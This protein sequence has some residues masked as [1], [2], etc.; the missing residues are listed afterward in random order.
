MRRIKNI[1]KI[2]NWLTNP[3]T[4]KKY[5]FSD[6]KKDFD[7]YSSEVE[8]KFSTK[9]SKNTTKKEIL[10]YEKY[11]KY[12]LKD[13]KD[14]KEKF[15][16]LLHKEWIDY[17]CYCWKSEII[18]TKLWKR[19]Y[20]IEHFLPRS[21]FPEL[22]VNLLNWLPVC[23]SCNGVSY[24]WTKNPLKNWKEIFHP[25]FGFLN[26]SETKSFDKKYSF[27]ED[28]K[29]SRYY[30]YE[31]N[32]SKFFE[33]EDLYKSSKSTFEAQ[34]ELLKLEDFLI[35]QKDFSEK[36]HIE[37][38]YIDYLKNDYPTNYPLN[39]QDILKFAN[40]KLKKDLIENLEL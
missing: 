12:D 19:S 39:E 27:C 36:S 40:W 20:D 2:I 28:D 24:K 35:S 7:F 30:I 14:L 13:F 8:K 11:S 22:S 21:K 1:E 31:S 4:W 32:H 37:F 16:R 17:C 15:L 3:L 23:K 33:L 29:F 9:K 18:F 6:L 10:F 34:D 5:I 25:Y 38:D 26:S